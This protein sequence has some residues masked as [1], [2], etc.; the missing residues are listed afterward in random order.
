M[1]PSL[2]GLLVSL[3]IFVLA[4]R[5]GG[6]LIIPLLASIAFGSTSAVIL[7]KLGGSTPLIYTTFA[8]LLVATV[9]ARR[10]IW[11]DLGGAFARIPDLWFLIALMVYAAVSAIL[12]P[13]LFA[14]HT[15]VFAR[16]PGV[17][18]YIET[19][20]GP[21]PG[22]ITQTGYFVLNGLTAIALCVLLL[23]RPRWNELRRGF[24]AL[25][26][27]HAGFG[28]LDL[29]TKLA[30]L[31]DLLEPIRTAS[32]AMLTESLEGG[33]H[34]VVGAF[35]EASSYAQMALAA[36][37]FTFTYG[38]R[39]RS[40]PALA[41]AAVLFG[42]LVISTSSTAYVGLA[43][44]CAAWGFGFARSALTLRL[45]RREL[46]IA[47]GGLVA[48]ALALAIALASEDF[49]EPL[50]RLVNSM[51]FEKSKSASGQERAYMNVK[52]LQGFV[53]TY[54]LGVGFGSSRAS[55][56][57]IAVLSQTGV[58]GTA[59]MAILLFRVT[60]GVGRAGEV[61][62]P[63][64]QATIAGVRAAALASIFAASIISNS[65]DPGI[66]FFIAFAVICSARANWRTEIRAAARARLQPA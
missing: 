44:L 13:R 61:L 52:S 14:G 57:V 38:S 55:S 42:L 47:M 65:A 23:H 51:V 4:R 11:R 62:D 56:W 36:L 5:A 21:V 35:P 50:T 29:A 28:A 41:I 26:A 25:C 45:E 58:V 15:T 63:A 7:T 64:A 46:V 17:F 2:M 33:F 48:L 39:M 30:G 20:L 59:M 10:H 40:R 54:G 60:A 24:L 22:N 3:V 18:V 32:Y 53:D 34:R 66:L 9:A 6:P 1:Q 16:P 19:S 43:G 31:G 37:A 8:A 49:F 27:L 12:L